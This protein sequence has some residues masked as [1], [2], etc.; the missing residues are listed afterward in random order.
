MVRV[1][2]TGYAYNE[3]LQQNLTNYLENIRDVE[4]E[5]GYFLQLEQQEG[6]Q[7]AILID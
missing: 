6:F 1:E 4:V 2:K 5:L 3:K 7:Q